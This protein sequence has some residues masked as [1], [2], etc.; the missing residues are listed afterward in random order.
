[1][2]VELVIESI[3]NETLTHRNC[4]QQVAPARQLPKLS[5]VPY[6]GITSEGSTHITFAHCII[7]YLEQVGGHPEFIKL[8]D[9]GIKGN[10][11]FMHLELNNLEIAGLVLKWIKKVGRNAK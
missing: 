7:N 11:H 4:Y 2:P 5:S 9:I 8:P 6:L 3:G 10:G 1:L